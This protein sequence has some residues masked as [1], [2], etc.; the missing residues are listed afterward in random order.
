VPTLE[1][2]SKEGGL[3]WD[4]SCLLLSTIMVPDDTSF[5]QEYAAALRLDKA[6]PL[7]DYQQMLTKRDHVL[8][9]K[10]V[11]RQRINQMMQTR[12]IKANIAGAMLWDLHTAA[13]AHPA[14][15]SKSKIEFT[16]DRISIAQK[17]MGSLT[18]QRA[19][20]RQFRPVIHWCAALAYQ[21]RVFGR[22][23][24][25]DAK[26]GYV[27]DVVIFDFLE[28]GESFLNFAR[29]RVDFPAGK[30]ESFWSAPGLVPMIA[31][32]PSW[33]DAHML[34]P[35]IELG[36]EFLETVSH[37]VVERDQ[38]KRNWLITGPR[39]RFAIVRSLRKSS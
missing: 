2:Q 5:R 29:E 13:A 38:L 16:I 25:Q 8:A 7:P 34:R 31:R 3:R 39:R 30:R 22:P 24:P 11:R 9:R 23:F 37:Y 19:A 21:E 28:L 14:I 20:W 18:T 17:K 6:R 1:I 32:Q 12:R 15:A 36:S 4:A 35:G 27:G 26:T 10:F 33:P